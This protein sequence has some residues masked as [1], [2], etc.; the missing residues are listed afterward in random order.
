MLTPTETAKLRS[1]WAALKA[2]AGA[3]IPPHRMARLA[4]QHLATPN[5]QTSEMGQV[6]HIA[7]RC[8]QRVRQMIAEGHIGGAA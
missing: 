3:P 2:A 8:S 4:S 5:T 1:N 7:E 6:L